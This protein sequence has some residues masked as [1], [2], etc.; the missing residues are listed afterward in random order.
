MVHI[1]HLAQSPTHTKCSAKLEEVPE[2]M[3]ND[4]RV[5]PIPYF[6]QTLRHMLCMWEK[7]K[8]KLTAGWCTPYDLQV[9]L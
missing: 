5:I 1:M 7:R 8:P 2:K 3:L 4:V 6:Y 9:A